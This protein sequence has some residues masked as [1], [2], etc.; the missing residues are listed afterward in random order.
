MVNALAYRQ[1]IRYPTQ[2][3]THLKEKERR[4]KR[5]EGRRVG[6]SAAEDILR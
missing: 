4:E 2:S 6:G 1:P 3:H 5:K